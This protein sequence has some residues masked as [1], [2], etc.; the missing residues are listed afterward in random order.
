MLAPKLRGGGAGVEFLKDPNDL[1]FGEA[2]FLHVSLLGPEARN[3]QFQPEQFCH[4]MSPVIRRFQGRHS[5]VCRQHTSR[6]VNCW[7]AGVGARRQA[8]YGAALDTSKWVRP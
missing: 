7:N 5:I 6:R 8:R 2:S 3:S 1:G 4:L